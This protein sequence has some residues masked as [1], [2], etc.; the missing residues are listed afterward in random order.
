[1]DDTKQCVQIQKIW[2]KRAAWLVGGNEMDDHMETKPPFFFFFF[3][4]HRKQRV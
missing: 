2:F 4:V 3:L 1:M